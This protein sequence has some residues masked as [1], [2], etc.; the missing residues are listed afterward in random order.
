MNITGN[1]IFIPGSTSGIGLALALAL[2][3]KG[4]TVIVGGRRADLL[5]GIADRHP[6]IDTVQIDTT[7]T[8]SITRAANQV[9]ARH[10]DLNAVIAMAGV[11][12]VEDWHH[13]ATFL[14]SAEAV[15]TTNLLGPIRLIAAF[16]EH[17]QRQPAATII[18]VSSGLA[19]APLKVTP[20]YNASKAA[21][22][23]LT[24]TLRLQ[25]ADTS[26]QLIELEP[27]SVAT[28]LLPGQRD[29]SFAMPLDEFIDEVMT[30]LEA[31]RDVKE[32]QVERVKFLRYAEARGDYDHVVA[33]L[34][35]ADPHGNQ[36]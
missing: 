20:S 31:D 23:M 36:T 28:D 11:M 24:E 26:I 7:D 2:H 32:I 15:I 5:D 6:G 1:T 12:R 18:T 19:F 14:D 9:L 29:S 34:N 30:I 33:T 21:V 25:Y 22:H 16:I 3:E 17:L 8:A 13:P 35:A 10:P 27:P 4:N